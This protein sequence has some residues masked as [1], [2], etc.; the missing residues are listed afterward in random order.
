[1]ETA[2]LK[3]VPILLNGRKIYVNISMMETA[4]FPSREPEKEIHALH[5][6]ILPK[7]FHAEITG[8][9]YKI[10]EDDAK[11]LGLKIVKPINTR[12]C[13]PYHILQ[14]DS[15]NGNSI[16][17]IKEVVRWIEINNSKKHHHD[18]E[19]IVARQEH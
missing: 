13:E 19:N 18:E 11:E 3:N 1:M 4:N 5:G 12:K 6:T 7:G 2:N 10:T 16:S 15:S 9:N 14:I 8:H 17:A